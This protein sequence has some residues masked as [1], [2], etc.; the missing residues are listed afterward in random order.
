MSLPELV[1]APLPSPVQ[2]LGLQ[3]PSA[4]T[5]ICNISPLHHASC[6]WHIQFSQDHTEVG[7]IKKKKTSLKTT[8][9]IPLTKCLTLVKQREVSPRSDYSQ[10]SSLTR[11]QTALQAHIPDCQTALCKVCALLQRVLSTSKHTQQSLGRCWLQQELKT[12]NT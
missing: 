3:V 1:I 6:L 9:L 4:Q 5:H 12:L 7:G 11:L 10:S 2:I 8:K